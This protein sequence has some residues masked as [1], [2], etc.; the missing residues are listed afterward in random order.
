MNYLFGYS[1]TTYNY[2]SSSLKTVV[3]T[4]NITSIPNF[5]FRNNSSIT[6]IILP[7]SVTS[8]GEASFYKTGIKTIDL[9]NV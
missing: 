9:K 1:N 7:D 8:I 4:G 5:A 6:S 2:V 3:I